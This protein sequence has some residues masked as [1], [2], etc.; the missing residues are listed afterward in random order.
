M[1]PQFAGIVR[2]LS[3]LVALASVA[4]GVSAGKESPPVP[5]VPVPRVDPAR[6]AGLWYEIA[7]IPNRFQNPCGANVTARY[8]I[9]KN[10]KIRVI[11]RCDGKDGRVRRAEGIAKFVDPETNAR[12]KVSFVSFLGI[13]PFWGSYWVLGLGEDYEYAVVGSP[14]RKY[15]WILARSPRPDPQ[16]LEAAW[17]IVR[18]QGYDSTRFQ[19]S[20][21]DSTAGP[22]GAP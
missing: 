22:P 18:E 3:V 7:R 1:I 21:Q 12:L 8:E 13:R 9:R 10:G 19:V 15:G 17:R 16:V 5:P 6:Y 11:N 20:P 14:D 4:G 2:G